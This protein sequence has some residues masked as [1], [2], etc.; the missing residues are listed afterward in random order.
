MNCSDLLMINSLCSAVIKNPCHDIH[1]TRFYGHNLN[2]CTQTTL[3]NFYILNAIILVTEFMD[4]CTT[5]YNAMYFE[6][7]SCV[8]Y[9]AQ[10]ANIV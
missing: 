10:T 8:L 5:L 6:S 9:Y 7:L 2:T 3:R 4:F 1:S